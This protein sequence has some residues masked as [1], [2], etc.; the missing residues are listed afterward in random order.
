[1]ASCVYNSEGE[2][3]GQSAMEGARCPLKAR[4]GA[5]Q[6]LLPCHEAAPFLYSA[7]GK[8]RQVCIAGDAAALGAL[9]TRFA[10]C[11]RQGGIA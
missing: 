7:G 9:A 4:A 8:A 3:P 2:V 1:M 11:C 6:S 5:G 10:S